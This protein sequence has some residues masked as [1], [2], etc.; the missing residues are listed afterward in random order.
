MTESICKG[1]LSEVEK[2]LDQEHQ[3]PKEKVSEKIQN[4]T[5]SMWF[6]ITLKHKEV[7][8]SLVLSLPQK[9]Y[10]L[11]NLSLR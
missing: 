10:K 11:F 4:L 7:E 3:E 5:K 9:I 1:K 6:R 8:Y 2:D